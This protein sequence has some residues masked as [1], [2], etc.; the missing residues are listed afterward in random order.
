M[1]YA[2]APDDQAIDNLMSMIELLVQAVTTASEPSA[3]S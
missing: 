1:D 3:P 2:G